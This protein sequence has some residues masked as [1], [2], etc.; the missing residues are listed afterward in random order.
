MMS[1]SHS[2]NLFLAKSQNVLLG[3]NF[4]RMLIT[5]GIHSGFMAN[6]LISY[7]DGGIY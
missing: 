7:S 2:E 4:S 6:K 5:L 1:L 3:D